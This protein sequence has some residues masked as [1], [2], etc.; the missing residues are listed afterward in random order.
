MNHS[1]LFCSDPAPLCPAYLSGMA[2][3]L[4]GPLVYCYAEILVVLGCFPYFRQNLSKHGTAQSE[5]IL[6][7][8]GDAKLRQNSFIEYFF[9]GI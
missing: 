4:V 1:V 5:F 7:Y 8:Y 3:I 6:P 2:V 9:Q